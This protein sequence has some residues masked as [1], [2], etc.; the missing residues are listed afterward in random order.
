MP[1]GSGLVV[2][3]DI[4]PDCG[5]D[6]ACIKDKTT[7][8]GNAPTKA[9]VLTGLLYRHWKAWQEPTRSHIVY[10]PLDGGTAARP[11]ARRV[12]RAA[13]LGR[14]RRR[15]RRLAGR[16][17][18][19]LRARHR[20]A[21]RGLD[22]RR[23]LP[24]SD[25]AAA[26]RSGSRRAPAPTRRRTIRR[27]AAGSRIARRRAPATNPICGSCGST[28][29]RPARRIASRRRSTTGSS[30]SP[31]RPTA[32]S[33]F[34]TA[35]KT[36]RRRDLRSRRSTAAL[37]SRSTATAP[38][39]AVAVSRDGKTLYFDALSPDRPTDIYAVD[40]RGGERRSSV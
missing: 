39:S 28:I 37:R 20:A 27:T 19:R 12:R 33:I 35:P 3:S 26:T 18:A 32:K 24:R 30:R 38:P 6:P 21:S 31:G 17:R 36:G 7:A 9:R 34:V 25:R 11:H 23:S 13:V 10:V 5:V 2:V 8:E 14:R 1:D 16:Q 22:E 4:Y 15:I 29:A 40:K